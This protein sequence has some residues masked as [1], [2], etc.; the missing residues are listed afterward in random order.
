MKQK[1]R[2]SLLL[3]ALLLSIAGCKRN[4]HRE[5][6]PPKEKQEIAPA[7]SD[8]NQGKETRDKEDRSTKTQADSQQKTDP[9]FKAAEFPGGMVKFNQA[10]VSKFKT[11]D[12]EEESIRI[13]ISFVVEKD[14]SLRNIKLIQDPGYGTG[15]EAIRVLRTMPKWKPA[16]Q[17][18]KPI[19]SQFTL[20]ITINVI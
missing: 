20:P 16:L 19:V 2:Y 5:H 3:L 13:I 7:N 9:N 18:G 6:T 10:F 1:L 17:N 12:I 4:R 14:G 11:P 8:Q 15:E